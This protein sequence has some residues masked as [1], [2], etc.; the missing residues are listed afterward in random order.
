MYPSYNNLSSLVKSFGNPMS[1]VVIQN[2]L[3]ATLNFWVSDTQAETITEPSAITA[4]GREVAFAATQQI[5]YVSGSAVA[6]SAYGSSTG[7]GYDNTASCNVGR[8]RQY[9]AAHPGWQPHK[10]RHRDQRQPAGPDADN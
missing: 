7:T 5:P 1:T 2:N 9:F 8:V 3:N 10:A 4:N 6:G